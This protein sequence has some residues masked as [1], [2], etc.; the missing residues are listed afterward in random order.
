MVYNKIHALNQR[1]TKQI[2]K[3]KP[4]LPN[5]VQPILHYVSLHT[6][7]QRE[8]VGVWNFSNLKTITSKAFLQRV[9]AKGQGHYPR[10]GWLLVWPTLR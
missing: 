7:W 9:G 4:A 1:S 10:F 2:K 8:I 6:F 3:S 5:T